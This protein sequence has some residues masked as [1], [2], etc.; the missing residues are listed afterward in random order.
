MIELD[1]S[2]LASSKE[3]HSFGN[4]LGDADKADLLEYLRS[5]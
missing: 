5:L 3:G 2:K 4:D 1:T